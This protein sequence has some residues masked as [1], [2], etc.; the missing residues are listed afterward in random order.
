MRA[1]VFQ[2]VHEVKCYLAEDT[3]CFAHAP[4]KKRLWSILSAEYKCSLHLG[5]QTKI[6]EIIQLISYEN[7]ERLGTDCLC[8]QNDHWNS[9]LSKNRPTCV[10]IASF[11]INNTAIFCWNAVSDIH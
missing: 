9:N 6:S 5:A 3:A 10:F 7:N 1:G 8:D 2:G 4:G 11:S